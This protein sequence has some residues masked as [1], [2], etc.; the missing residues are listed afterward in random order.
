MGAG[1]GRCGRDCFYVEPGSIESLVGHRVHLLPVLAMKRY[2]ATVAV[3]AIIFCGL[4]AIFNYL[5][6]PYV[7][8]GFKQADADRLSRIEQI[9]Q[10]RITKPWYITQLSADQIVLGTSTSARISPS[11][12]WP[13]AHSYNLSIPGLTPYEMFRFLEHANATGPIDKLFLGLDFEAFIR[14]EPIVQPGFAERRLATG[15]EELHALPFEWQ[16]VEDIADTLFSLPALNLSLAALTGSQDVRRR[17]FVDGSWDTQSN[18]YVGKSGFA[19]AGKVSIYAHRDEPADLDFNLEALAKT[20]RFAH[21]NNIETRIYI[22]P[23]HVFMLDLWYRV[24][25]KKWWRD[26]NLRLVSVNEA[27]A[28]ELG[29]KPFPLYGFNQVAG[30]VDEPIRGAANAKQATFDDVIHFRKAFGSQI[31]AAVWG[32]ASGL[33]YELNPGSV[34]AYLENVEQLRIGF[35]AANQ[36]LAESIRS[37]IFPEV[38]QGADGTR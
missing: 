28:K 35:E 30:I 29:V 8:Y 7:V 11:P 37:S 13:R 23:M 34:D 18:Q 9:Y 15:S 16:R 21:E 10:M 36:G 6:D 27:V 19:L 38:P 2:L 1:L 31:M 12:V 22:S 5:V 17:Y 33:A 24:G 3:L 32:D 14:P 26:F 4:V 20:L 25:Y